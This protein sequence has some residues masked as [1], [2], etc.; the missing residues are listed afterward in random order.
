MSGCVFIGDINVTIFNETDLTRLFREAL[1]TKI[2]KTRKELSEVE[3]TS[4]P[5]A[6]KRM[7][8]DLNKMVDLLSKIESNNLDVRLVSRDY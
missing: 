6:V 8:E 2:I 3:S 5:I 7:R 4:I 1:K